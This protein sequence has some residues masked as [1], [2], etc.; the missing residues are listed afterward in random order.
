MTVSCRACLANSC[1][2]MSPNLHWTASSII[3]LITIWRRKEG[4]FQYNFPAVAVVTD[5]HKLAVVPVFLRAGEPGVGGVGVPPVPGEAVGLGAGQ[6]SLVSLPGWLWSV[7]A[8]VATPSLLLPARSDLT[9]AAE[10]CWRP[11]VPGQR[12]MSQHRLRLF[13][14]LVEMIIQPLLGH[15]EVQFHLVLKFLSLVALLHVSGMILAGKL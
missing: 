7:G 15:V 5:L 10:F 13:V 1:P 2:A 11:R 12:E 8:A 6:T 14:L 9:G 3:S 4:N